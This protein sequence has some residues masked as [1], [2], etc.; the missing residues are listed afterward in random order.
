LPALRQLRL[1]EAVA[2]AIGCFRQRLHGHVEV[3]ICLAAMLERPG[4]VV[5]DP[6]ASRV[7]ASAYP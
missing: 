5:S 1:G 6:P 7:G 2:M 4:L 3:Q